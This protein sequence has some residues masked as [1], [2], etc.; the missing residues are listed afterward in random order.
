M[1]RTE[2]YK[3]F[4]R[5]MIFL[6]GGF[7]LLFLLFWFSVNNE[8][9][10]IENGRVLYRS[11]AVARNREITAPYEGVM[12]IEKVLDIWET[13]GPPYLGIYPEEAAAEDPYLADNYSNQF[14][15]RKF[16]RQEDKDGEVQYHFLEEEL[17]GRYYITNLYFAYAGNWIW[18]WDYYFVALMLVSVLV[19]IALSP[20]ISE[21]YTLKTADILLTTPN[22]R[23]C[24]FRHKTGAALLVSS[25]IYW[26]FLGIILVLYGT[27][28]GLAGLK[29]SVGFT[30]I[31]YWN[32]ADTLGESIFTLVTCGWA[33]TMALAVMV[34]AV[35]AR[36]RQSF[37][38]V[39]F[40]L[41]LYLFPLTLELMIL[42]SLGGIGA[43]LE[44]V[45]QSMPVLYPLLF[46]EQPL[47][48][49][50]LHTVVLAAAAVYAVWYGRK[51][52]CTLLN[53]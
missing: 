49:R 29:M 5:K 24:L 16:F 9:R 10:V 37:T 22:G 41:C 34:I 11:E 38:S 14:A 4:S 6:G 32:P 53:P 3:I 30:N 28:Y 47:V 12:T 46:M 17:T 42:R 19:I 31:P 52:Y 8:E 25:L 33:A 21:E 15:G 35:S 26:F 48:A 40:S 50:I 51:K 7:I 23:E 27:T 39:L 36:C 45:M 20:V 2:I 13:Y 44:I 18:F 43:A 1:F